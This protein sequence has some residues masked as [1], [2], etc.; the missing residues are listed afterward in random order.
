[1]TDN[2]NC[3]DFYIDQDQNDEKEIELDSFS[4]RQNINII[5]E[6]NCKIFVKKHKNGCTI[7][8][9]CDCDGDE[10]DCDFEECNSDC[11]NCY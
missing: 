3:E 10:W 9:R 6:E 11:D 8:I 5:C 2:K 7:E 1:M 4:G